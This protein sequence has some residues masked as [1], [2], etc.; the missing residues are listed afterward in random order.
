MREKKKLPGSFIDHQIETK[1]ERLIEEDKD[2]RKLGQ[3][4]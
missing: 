2:E 1:S 4:N 3:Q